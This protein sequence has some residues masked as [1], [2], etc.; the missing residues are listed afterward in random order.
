MVDHVLI[1][2]LI[3]LFGSGGGDEGEDGVAGE[4]DVVDSRCRWCRDAE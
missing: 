2:F 1:L 3:L 4:E